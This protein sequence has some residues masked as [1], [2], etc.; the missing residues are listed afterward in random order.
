MTTV[1]VLCWFEMA[2]GAA[3]WEYSWLNDN[4]Y[5][6]LLIWSGVWCCFMIILLIK[7][8]QWL[9][10]AEWKWNCLFEYARCIDEFSHSPRFSTPLSIRLRC[11]EYALSLVESRI[12]CAST[13]VR[14][15]WCYFM[16]ILLI[17][18]QQLL[19][20]AYLKWRVVLLHKKTL[21]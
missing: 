20:S 3:S 19:S 12:L 5:C 13:K 10:S 14:S 8:Q 16:R 9:C 6:P 18:W 1:T 15:A 4:S 11:D 17:K 21:D 7:W 2:C